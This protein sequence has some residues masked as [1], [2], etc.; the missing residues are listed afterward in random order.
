MDVKIALLGAGKVGQ[1]FLANLRKRREQLSSRYGITFQ[2]VSICDLAGGSIISPTGLK[3][4]E[5]L[6]ILEN[7]G[8]LVEY[9]PSGQVC[10]KGMDVNA[11]IEMS[12]ADVVL[13]SI[14]FN[15]ETGEPAL[16]YIRKAL[17]LR[18][19]VV[20]CNKGPVS[21]H[22]KELTSLAKANGVRFLFGGTMMNGTPVINII[23][24]S[25]R[26]DEV[27]EIRG[28]LNVSANYI[29]WAMEQGLSY[30]EGI[31]EARHLG[32]L[33]ADA[34]LDLEGHD[35]LA[36]LVI[37]LNILT[38]GDFPSHQIVREG[39]TQITSR[40]I[41]LGME[42]GLR[43]KMMVGAARSE[44]GQWQGQVG[45]QKLEESDPFY[46]LDKTRNAL[47]IRT[48][49]VGDIYLEGPG[50]GKIRAGNALLSDLLSI[51]AT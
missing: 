8:S 30:E 25:F 36:K 47:L 31:K 42:R 35:S 24:N 3:I 51:Y 50:A 22:Y 28:V 21:M 20:T 12:H 43:Y 15:Q 6:P 27:R 41:G 1:G 48:E 10:V 46:N 9:E 19:H 23:S 34:S 37:L 5:I 4:S 11:C 49:T 16:S 17:G 18:K 2:L 7:N 29:L 39:I 26:A 38:N 14:V 40:D 45:L 32:Y 44:D 33:E 13:E